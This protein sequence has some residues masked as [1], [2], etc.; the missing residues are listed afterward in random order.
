ESESGGGERPGEARG[1]PGG[2]RARTAFTP[3]QLCRLQKT[4]Q[5]QRYPGAA[6]RGA[7]SAALQLSGAQIKTWF[8]NRWMKLKREI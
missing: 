1:T 4:F 5:R 2:R 6:E 3:E 7:L 8:R